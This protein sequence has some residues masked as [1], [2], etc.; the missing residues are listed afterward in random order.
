MR[1]NDARVSEGRGV[2]DGAHAEACRDMLTCGRA[3]ECT[4]WPP[5]TYFDTL[6]AKVRHVDVWPQGQLRHYVWQISKSAPRWV[7]AGTQNYNIN[8]TCLRLL[9]PTQHVYVSLSILSGPHRRCSLMQCAGRL[10]RAWISM[11]N[12]SLKYPWR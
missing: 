5:G 6:C 11:M 1:F 9:V 3:S 8:F 12:L 7:S 4:L 2:V 10:Y